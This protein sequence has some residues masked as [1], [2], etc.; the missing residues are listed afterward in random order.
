M[1]Y[2]IESLRAE[3]ARCESE[4]ADLTAEPGGSARHY[5]TI[6][7]LLEQI[8]QAKAR[9]DWLRYQDELRAMPARR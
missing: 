8:D 2:Q 3:I 4:I 5:W 6:S 7:Q 1:N 9:I